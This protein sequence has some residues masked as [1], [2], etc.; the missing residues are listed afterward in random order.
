MIDAAIDSPGI[1]V[2]ALLPEKKPAPET[3][4]PPAET[5]KPAADK[6]LA[7]QPAEKPKAKALDIWPLP[8]TGKV[9]LRTGFVQSGHLKVAP[10]SATLTLERERAHLELAEGQVCGI[11]LP[12]TLDA[13]PQG[14]TAAARLS[15]KKLPIDQSVKCLSADRVLLTGA[16]DMNAELRTEGKADALLKNLKGTVN[17]DLRNGQVMKFA[18]I[19]N[20]LSMRNIVALAEQ[21]G[22]K[23]AAEG[24]PFRQLSAKGH[25]KDGYFMLDEGVFY[26]NA[27][28]LGANGWISLSDYQS[29]LTVLVAPLALLT[30]TIRKLPLLGYVIGGTFTS[31]P[32]AVS[33]DIRDPLVVPLGPGAITQDLLGVLGRAISLPSQLAPAAP[34]PP[35]R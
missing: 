32:V 15:A 21:G 12:F 10:V 11:A 4:K 35:R 29:R 34:P 18:L 1:V 16:L 6:P 22:P 14:F 30:E 27:I 33:G 31:L 9:V 13:T 19:G 26:S 23:L 24:F 20:I 2:D 7:K 28:G 25:F 3:N 17:A 8:A 5:K